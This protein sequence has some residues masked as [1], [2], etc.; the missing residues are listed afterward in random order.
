VVALA[1]VSWLE[2][3]GLLGRLFGQQ[4][5]KLAA[6]FLVLGLREE[7]AI[8]FEFLAVDELLYCTIG[9]RPAKPLC[10]ISDIV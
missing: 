10:P 7:L 1:V 8:H 4:L 3:E 6:L 5:F 9:R 2:H